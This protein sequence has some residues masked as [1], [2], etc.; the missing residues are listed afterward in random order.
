MQLSRKS[1]SFV[2]FHSLRIS[3]LIALIYLRRNWKSIMFVFLLAVSGVFLQIKFN[4]ININTNTV[5]EALVGTYQEHDLPLEV[6]RL[7][8]ESL[9]EVDENS[10]IIPKLASNWEV[11]TEATVYKFRLKDNL[12]WLDGSRVKSSD[13]EFVIPNIEISYPDDQIIEFKLKEAY[14][15]FPSL[16]IKPV[17]RKGTLIGTGPYKISKVEKSRIFITKMVLETNQADLP[18]II[19][20]F[21]PNEKTALTGFSLGEV[22]SLMGISYKN[23][24]NSIIGKNYATDYTKIVTIF[25]NMEDE[26]LSNRS[27]RQALSFAAPVIEGEVEAN[28]P[29]PPMSWAF[30]KDVKN[31]LENSEEAKAALQR[32][33]GN[34]SAE[35]LKK[36]IILTTTP[37]LEEIG[38]KVIMAWREIGINAILRVESGVPQKFQA[39]LI[40]QSIP[41]DPDQYFLWHETQ[42]NTNL[43]KYS[44]KR[45]DKDLE[46][47]R[48]FTQESKRKEVYADFQRVL[49]EDAPAAFLYFPK[50]NVVFYKKSEEKIEKILPLQF[51]ALYQ[52]W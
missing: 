6:T 39:L 41:P 27:L 18:K 42:K 9:V 52:N 40:T 34:S 15:A 30:N 38:K 17:F 50:Y 23:G 3:Y 36:E 49:L 43:T 29:Y 44:Q 14:S 1:P 31:Y 2:N 20:R 19:I 28:N 4:F 35:L 16:L 7:L 48:K 22:Q 8:S 24:N 10:R 12:Y 33:K 37:Q 51:S 45:V 47:G 13:I 11:N 46:D 25:F 32:A 21:Y 26:V 5:S